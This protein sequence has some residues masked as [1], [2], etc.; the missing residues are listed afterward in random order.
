MDELKKNTKY[1]EF[2]CIDNITGEVWKIDDFNDILLQLCNTVQF[3][4]P[5]DKWRQGCILPF[6]KKE[7]LVKL[8]TTVESP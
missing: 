1:D 2:F 4:S 8:P 6:P 3:G 5:V 7:I